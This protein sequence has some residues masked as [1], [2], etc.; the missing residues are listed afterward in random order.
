MNDRYTPQWLKEVL[1]RGF[2]PTKI[3][4][5]FDDG[6]FAYINAYGDKKYIAP[7]CKLYT[8]EGLP[9]AGKTTLLKRLSKYHNTNTVNQILPC[10]PI[11]DQSMDFSFYLNSEE[12]K[13]K[14]STHSDK[15]VCIF[16]R[17]YVST[18]AFYWAYDKIKNT[19]EYDRVYSWYKDAVVNRNIWQPFTVFYIDITP[20]TSLKRKNRISSEANG[21]L[22]ENSAFL[23][24][25]REYYAYFYKNIE[26]HT[27]VCYISGDLTLSDIEKI[28]VK[29]IYEK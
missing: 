11:D 24:Y 14:E 28:I 18:L 15:G 10:E 20:S 29:E 8:L 6:L 26:S 13:T 27:K 9:G 2:K 19:N 16:D 23:E 21:N 5:D 7:N 22:W 12:L 1:D 25:F 3:Y 17:Y 4:H